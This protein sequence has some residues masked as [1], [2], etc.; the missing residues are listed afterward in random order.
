MM[1]AVVAHWRDQLEG[2]FACTVGQALEGVHDWA[3]D[4][5]MRGRPAT[6]RIVQALIDG[7]DHAGGVLEVRQPCLRVD[8]QFIRIHSLPH[9]GLRQ[10]GL[11]V[12]AVCQRAGGTVS[13]DQLGG[14]DVSATV[15]KVTRITHRTDGG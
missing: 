12:A 11:S 9:L 1:S 15:I 7:V 4:W 8:Q 2:G 3:L 5:G 10:H 14:L 13:P 6:Q